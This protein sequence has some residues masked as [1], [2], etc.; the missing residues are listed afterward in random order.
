MENIT[1]RRRMFQGG[2]QPKI[3]TLFVQYKYE[4]AE[5]GDVVFIVHKIKQHNLDI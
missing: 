2:K 1:I 4:E 5:L 3:D